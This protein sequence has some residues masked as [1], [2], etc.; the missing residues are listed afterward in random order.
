M[1]ARL[2]IIVIAENAITGTTAIAI[3]IKIILT[4]NLGYEYNFVLHSIL[5]ELIMARVCL[6]C[7]KELSQSYPYNFCY[8]CQEKQ[9]EKMIADGEDLVDAEGYAAMLGLDSVE[10][11]KRKARDGLLAPRIPGIK[12]WLWRRKD[13]EIWFKQKQR[14]GDAFRRIA[15]GITDNLRTC[16]YDTI[17]CLSLSDKIGSKVYGAKSVLGTTGTGQVKPIKLVKV[18]RPAA[19][20]MLQQLPR[21][22]FPELGSITDWSEL[23]YDRINKD[24]IVRLEAYF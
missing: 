19:L 3:A 9:L 5:L 4:Y 6:H 20:N 8:T 12:R 15:L 24:L 16:R 10:Q 1:Q 2:V 23:T 22:D 11:L 17:I 7:G 18:D 21:K 14:E 13:I